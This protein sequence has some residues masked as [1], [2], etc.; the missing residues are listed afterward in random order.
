MKKKMLCWPLFGVGFENLGRNRQPCEWDIPRPGPDEL[1]VRIDAIGLCF[2]DVKLI[3]AGE[4]HPRVISKDLSRD[5]VIPGHEAVMTVVEA[6]ED[7]ADRFRPGDR[8][9]IQADIYVNGVGYA[10][11]YAINGGMAQY[12]LLDQRVLNGDEGCYLLPLAPET[13]AG[14]AALIEPWTCVIASYMIEHRTAPRTGGRMLVA[15]AVGTPDEFTFGTASAAEGP[16]EID[17]LSVNAAT[18]AALVRAFPTARFRDIDAPPGPEVRYDD[19]VLCELRDRGLAESL[20]RC[21]AQDAL[22]SFVGRYPNEG[23]AFDVGSIHYQGWLYQGCEGRDVR[24]AYGRNVRSRLRKGGTCWLLGGAGAM[25]QMHTQLAVEAPDGPDRILVTDVDDTRIAKLSA[26]LAP[27]IQARGIEFKALNPKSFPSPDAFNAAVGE[28]APGGYDDIVMLVP[29]VPILNSAVPFL[30]DDGLM[31]IFAGIPTGNDA[32]LDVG[33]IVRRGVRH[34]GSSGSRT[35]HLRHT[36]HLVES[37]QI[38]PASALAAVGGMRS[39]WEGINGVADARFPGKTVVFPH[40]E[41]LPLTSMDDL[42]EL[43]P[44]I[45][46]T[47]S[48]DGFYTIETE[49]A[50]FRRFGTPE[51]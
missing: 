2:S 31:N 22:I 18:R 47:L 4:K 50:L 3:R 48:P 24:R 29:V 28:F 9:I 15:M 8:F 38:N 51:S 6:G 40:C 1:L 25:G 37:G 11:G 5:P 10:Y 33:A 12:S 21:G 16:A 26:R 35:H 42:P 20:A 36:L 46:D 41:E 23:W 32:I 34:I 45:R 39:L 19:I 14:L 13:P 43:A 7:I 44:E 17:L 49:K 30:A 27:A